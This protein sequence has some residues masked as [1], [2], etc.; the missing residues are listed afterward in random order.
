MNRTRFVGRWCSRQ[1]RLGFKK[2]SWN[3]KSSRKR[4]TGRNV[5]L[6]LIVHVHNYWKTVIPCWDKYALKMK[7]FITILLSS[8]VTW[9]AISRRSSSGHLVLLRLFFVKREFFLPLLLVGQSLG[10]CKTPKDNLDCH[11]SCINKVEFNW[12]GWFSSNCEFRRV[13]A[14]FTGFN[15]RKQCHM[16]NVSCS[17]MLVMA[18]MF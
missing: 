5:E 1:Q 7:S 11:R 13:V 3:R 15:V 18:G 10:V 4:K 12:T 16:H 6:L 17:Q 14:V 2:R 8:S 9:M